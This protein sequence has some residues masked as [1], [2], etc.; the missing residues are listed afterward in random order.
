MGSPSTIVSHLHSDDTPG[1]DAHWLTCAPSDVLGKLSEDNLYISG[2]GDYEA[3]PG[4]AKADLDVFHG[5][6]TVE[7]WYKIGA[8]DPEED[9]VLGGVH[10]GVFVSRVV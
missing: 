7:G 9:L 6:N 5:T 10:F 2:A 1:S 8:G 4:H 3:W